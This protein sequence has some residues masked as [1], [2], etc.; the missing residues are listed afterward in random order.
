MLACAHRGKSWEVGGSM[1]L[2]FIRALRFAAAAALTGLLLA[3]VPGAAQAQTGIVHLRI[4]KAGF[5]VGA[6]GGTGSLVY[7]GVRYRLRIGGVGLG[8]IGIAEA[9]LSGVAYNLHRPSD[10]AGTY[11]AAGAGLAVV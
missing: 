3:A 8:T 2:H 11:G 7:N 1:T 9:R 6:G 4:V 10:I 5:I